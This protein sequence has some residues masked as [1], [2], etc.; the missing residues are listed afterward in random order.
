MQDERPRKKLR[1][2]SK[3]KRLADFLPP[4]SKDVSLALGSGKV[5][6]RAQR[7]SWRNTLS[8]PTNDSC[9]LPCAAP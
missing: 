9:A 5:C 8:C 4:P 1:P 2:S 3:G 7:P 6:D